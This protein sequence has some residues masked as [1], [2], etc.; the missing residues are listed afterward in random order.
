M[1]VAFYACPERI[2]RK[3]Q[4]PLTVEAMEKSGFFSWDASRDAHLVRFSGKPGTAF[5]HG[6]HG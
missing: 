2:H 1:R 4:E 5:L 6:L 3:K